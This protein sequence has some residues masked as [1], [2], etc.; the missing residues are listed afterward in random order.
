MV[1]TW[2]K[3]DVMHDRSSASS[4]RCLRLNAYLYPETQLRQ[5]GEFDQNISPKRSLT[6]GHNEGK[7]ERDAGQ[8]VRKR[9]RL[10]ALNATRCPQP[11]NCIKLMAMITY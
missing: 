1:T 6:D 4:A 10:S 9:R 7:C 11:S 2:A 3:A 5:L 8:V